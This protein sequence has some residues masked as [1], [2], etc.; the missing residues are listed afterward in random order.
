MAIR[1]IKNSILFFDIIIFLLSAASSIAYGILI[2]Q[3]GNNP[4]IT[5]LCASSTIFAFISVPIYILLLKETLYSIKLNLF[6]FWFFIIMAIVNASLGFVY[7]Y[8]IQG[9]LAIGYIIFG[10]IGVLL[11]SEFLKRKINEIKPC[12]YYS[13]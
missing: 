1:L 5:T 3:E 12:A 7:F 10:F 2:G 6:L 9:A 13:T 8:W 4:V 11:C